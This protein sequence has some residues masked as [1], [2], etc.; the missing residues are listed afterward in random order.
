MLVYEE[1]P[2]GLHCNEQAVWNALCWRDG[3]S[4]GEGM[5]A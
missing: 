2:G 3:F 1:M 4:G 5:A